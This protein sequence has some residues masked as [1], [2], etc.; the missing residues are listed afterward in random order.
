ML[1]RRQILLGAGAAIATIAP[2]KL[3]ASWTKE[4]MEQKNAN[5]LSR[6][7]M[8]LIASLAIREVQANAGI[9]RLVHRSFEP[10]SVEPWTWV[11]CTVPPAL[12]SP[13][14]GSRNVPRAPREI[15]IKRRIEA[16]AGIPVAALDNPDRLRLCLTPA[17]IA[18]AEYLQTDISRL[19]DDFDWNGA[20]YSHYFDEPFFNRAKEL[21]FDGRVPHDEEKY[22]VLSKNAYSYARRMPRFLEGPDGASIDGIRFHRSPYVFPVS[23]HD[24]NFAFARH[25][26]EIAFRRAPEPQ[27]DWGGSLVHVNE[28]NFGLTVYATRNTGRGGAQVTVEA[29]YGAAVT[30]PHHGLRIRTRT[31]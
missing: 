25:A 3:A 6:Q 23:G 18:I 24:N 11:P 9:A 12:Y 7:Q 5:G 16:T 21:L 1:N 20:R 19:S 22:F 30:R 15:L 26:I 13:E 31:A 2:A 27:G 8:S 29:V 17:C 14:P 10:E 28:N 4:P